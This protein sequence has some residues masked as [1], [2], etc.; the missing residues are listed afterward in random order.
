MT[1]AQSTKTQPTRAPIADVCNGAVRLCEM[2]YWD[3]G[4]YVYCHVPA[5]TRDTDGMWVCDVHSIP[6]R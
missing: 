4:E 3:G 6:A 1:T 2:T 5:R